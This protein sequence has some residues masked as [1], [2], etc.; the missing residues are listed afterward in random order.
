MSPPWSW[1]KIGDMSSSIFHIS[2]DPYFICPEYLRISSNGFDD[3]RKSRRR[4]KWTE[5]IKSPQWPGDL[6]TK[7]FT[8]SVKSHVLITYIITHA[9]IWYILILLCYSSNLNHYTT[10]S[11]FLHLPIAM[12]QDLSTISLSHLRTTWNWNMILTSAGSTVSRQCSSL[13]WGRNIKGSYVSCDPFLET[14]DYGT[15]C[16][17]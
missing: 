8:N 4:R 16:V 13:Q 11:L 2:P 7:T 12:K 14:Q 1:V 17:V 10:N 6:I 15:G 5:N 9:V 3:R